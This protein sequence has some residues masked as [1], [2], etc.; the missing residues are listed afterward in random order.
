MDPVALRLVFDLQGQ[1][2]GSPQHPV[3]REL[4]G[5]TR[6]SGYVRAMRHST[7]ES[8][9]FYLELPGTGRLARLRLSR[10]VAAGLGRVIADAQLAEPPRGLTS[11][12]LEV[13]TLLAAG[14]SNPA[15]AGHLH[16]SP[17][18]VST[19]VE[20]ILAKLDAD[21]RTAAGVKAAVNGWLKLPL[22]APVAQCTALAVS[23]LELPE[24]ESRVNAD[25]LGAP[26]G[27]RLALAYPARGDAAADGRQSLHGALLAVE[28]LN[29][30]GGIFGR[31][32]EAIH[33][34]AQLDSPEGLRE[35]FARLA[36]LAPDALL[37]SYADKQSPVLQA[38][39]ALGC[40]VLHTMTS[41]TQVA[42]ALADSHRFSRIFQAV[43]TETSY[44]AGLLR[45]TDLLR[46][47]DPGTGN[48]VV[49]IQTEAD[50]GRIDDAPTLAGLAGRGWS[51]AGT[52]PMPATPQA[53]AALAAQVLAEHPALVVVS[54]FMPQAMA[55][56]HLALVSAGLAAPVYGIY[57]P[58]VPVFAELAGPK[59]EGMVYS[60]VSG[61]YADDLGAR[62]CADYARRYGA[63]P[64]TSQAGLGYDLVQVL[65]AAWRL[66]GES[67]DYDAVCAAL[68]QVRH[69]GVNGGYA[70]SAPGQSALSYPDQTP[71]P[72]LGQAQLIYQIQGGAHRILDPAPYARADYHRPSW[73][74]TSSDA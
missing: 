66:A 64:G 53:C 28:Q 51:V 71:D 39:A 74:N 17:R 45:F 2:Q 16:T 4:L 48:R 43:P 55:R 41:A 57:A 38:A 9:S 59:A 58:S 22:P 10:P 36:E 44:G 70:F 6:L 25:P 20:R 56:M 26:A 63:A 65:A 49:F 34:D 13:L 52:H 5:S 40:P 14:L 47:A 31:P 7:Q 23:V 32:I 54:E 11:R 12:E 21:S 37:M 24:P 27:I 8:L 68:R 60:T 19:Q 69:R 30:G 50:D 67:S 73:T 42:A 29:A 1:V 62:F 33:V 35:T 72:S 15:I 18:T 61:T 3:L 46:R